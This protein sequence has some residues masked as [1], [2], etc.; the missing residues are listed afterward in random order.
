MIRLEAMKN[1]KT[2]MT[3]CGF[4]LMVAIA[5]CVSRSAGEEQNENSQGPSKE[6]S[7]MAAKRDDS[8][9]KQRLT[10][11]QYWVTRQRGT[12]KPFSGEY[13]NHKEKGSYACVCCGRLLFSSATKFESG[14]GWPSFWEALEKVNVTEKTDTSHG[15]VRTEIV[16]SGCNAHLGH[17]F[18]DGPDPTGKR[19]CINS[20]ALS[21]HSAAEKKGSREK[22]T[23][24]EKTP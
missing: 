20:A 7:S 24:A 4:G 11:V 2:V 17:V 12:E 8:E 13:W 6:G 19:Y 23:A 15:M 14:C 3:A 5:A 9:W 10:P 16:C 18:D 1:L 21:F 22:G